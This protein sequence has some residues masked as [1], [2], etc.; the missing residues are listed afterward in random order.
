MIRS[1]GI[2]LLEKDSGRDI[3]KKVCRKHNVKVQLIEQLVE[4]ELEQ[5]GKLRKRGLYDKFD[6]VLDQFIEEGEE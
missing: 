6:D 4:A 2:A 5:V 3:L 1:K